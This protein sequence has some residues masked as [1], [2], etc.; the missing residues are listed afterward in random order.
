ML[1]ILLG[2]EEG[3]DS[4]EKETTNKIISPKQLLQEK[5]SLPMRPVEGGC[6]VQSG[7]QDWS[8]VAPTYK[9]PKVW[10]LP[11]QPYNLALTQCIHQKHQFITME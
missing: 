11:G 9:P 5:E 6:L 3:I 4:N 8:L 1:Q 10:A 2:N 7:A